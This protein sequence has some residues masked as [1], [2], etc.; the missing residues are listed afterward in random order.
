MDVKKGDI[1][2]VRA[3]TFVARVIQFGMNIERW[4]WL[5]LNPFWK[6]VANHAAICIDDF[7]TLSDVVIAEATAKGITVHL[8]SSAYGSAK[9]ME[10]T[11]YR[12]ELSRD[13][14]GRLY[15]V[16]TSYKGVKYQFINF[17]Q[18]I[19]KIIFGIWLGRTHVKAEGKLYC[20]EYVALVLNRITFGKLFKK[21]WRTSPSGIQNW[22]ERN[23]VKVAEI[24]IDKEGNRKY[25][26][27]ET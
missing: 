20:T 6:R 2:L 25:T 21:Y 26:F 14:L 4:R 27:H 11:I 22:C 9:D 12:P 5:N 8:F 7:K 17:I 3:R 1:I 18:Y 15:H 24:F 13:E 10:I 23:C 19:P 16:A